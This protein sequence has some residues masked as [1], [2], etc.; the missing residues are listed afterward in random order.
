MK[1]SHTLTHHPH[2]CTLDILACLES[3]EFLQFQL[4]P[5]ALC[6]AENEIVLQGREVLCH[7][8]CLM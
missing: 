3:A 8:C 1:S 6:G 4:L 2:G 5:L 7:R